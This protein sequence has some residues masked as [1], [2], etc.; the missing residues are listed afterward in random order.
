M[1]KSQNKN[2]KRLNVRHK[3]KLVQLSI[4]QKS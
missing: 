1:V 2:V 4:A 3:R